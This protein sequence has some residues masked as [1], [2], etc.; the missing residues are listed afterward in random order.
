M[1]SYSRTRE[2]IY[3]VLNN[4]DK[5]RPKITIQ[6]IS[7]H[8]DGPGNELADKLAKLDTALDE[9]RRRVALRGIGPVIKQV[10]VYRPV[11]HQNSKR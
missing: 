11:E 4:L 2:D 5:C 9:K 6:W 10:I 1:Y 3:T 8:S 7:G